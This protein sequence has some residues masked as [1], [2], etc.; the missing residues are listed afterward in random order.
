MS[1]PILNA[2][3]S[4][5]S[6][7]SILNWISTKYPK[8]S[9]AINLALTAGYAGKSILRRLD[10]QG[11]RRSEDDYLTEH[12]KLLKQDKRNNRKALSQF[13]GTLGAVG[14]AGFGLARLAGAGARAA[15]QAGAQAATILPPGGGS[16][17]PGPGATPSQGGLLAPIPGG[18][19]PTQGKQGQALIPSGQPAMTPNQQASQV[20]HQKYDTVANNLPTKTETDFPHLPQFVKRMQ[21]AGKGPEEIDAL[22]R[23][24]PMLKPLV[25][26]VEQE[27]GQPFIERVKQSG[28]QQKMGAVAQFTAAKPQEQAAVGKPLES[29]K[30]GSIVVTPHG[31][32]EVHKIHGANAYVDIGGKLQ[33]VPVSEIEVP[34]EGMVDVVND[35]LKIPEVD[36]SSNVAAFGYNPEKQMLIMQ[37]HD[38]NFY[39]YYDVPP[40]IIENLATKNATPVTSGENQFGAWDPSDPHGSL[41]AALHQ[42]VKTDPKW[43]KAGKDQEANPNYFKYNTVYDYWNQL[44]RKKKK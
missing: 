31:S 13:V 28:Q 35:I 17:P 16:P 44:R 5:F 1:T 6:P 42:Y 15:T 9:N 32:G 4:G 30:A 34:P 18:P 39:T 21:E 33:K 10:P 11:K 12:E 37:F 19:I 2:V 29:T 41:G 27:T 20:K 14:G 38:G 40:D 22:A 43:K 25:E 24:S 3:R 8:Y 36:R 7:K 23:Q 26:K